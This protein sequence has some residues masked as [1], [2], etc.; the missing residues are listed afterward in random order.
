MRH[1]A[2]GSDQTAVSNLLDT[3]ES[4]GHVVKTRD[5]D[6]H[7]VAKL[8]LCVREAELLAAAPKPARGLLP[9]A[10]RQLTPEQLARLDQGLHDLLSSMDTLDEGYGMQPLP[11]AMQLNP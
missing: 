8:A 2:C 6:D 5:P 7:R 4:R 10:L 3:L 9:Q 1:Q 11:F